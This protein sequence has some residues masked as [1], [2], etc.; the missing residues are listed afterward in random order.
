MCEPN[1]AAEDASA[2]DDRLAPQ[3]GCARV[4]HYVVF[5]RR[6]SLCVSDQAPRRIFVERESAERHALIELDVVADNGCAA[7][8]DARPVI[9]EEARADLCAWM[10][11]YPRAVMRV[12][13][14]DARD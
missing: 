5:N 3:N 14:H 13:G 4:N 2:P 9:Y 1:V 11:I 7:D 6:M 12:L 8:D 10:N